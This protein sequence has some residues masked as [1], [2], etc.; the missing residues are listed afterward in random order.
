MRIK[1]LLFCLLLLPYAV[2]GEDGRVKNS[3]PQTRDVRFELYTHFSA[4][5]ILGE[6]YDNPNMILGGNLACIFYLRKSFALGFTLGAF[7]NEDFS[8]HFGLLSLGEG[9]AYFTVQFNLP[10]KKNPRWSFPF[11]ISAGPAVVLSDGGAG[12]CGNTVFETGMKFQIV[13]YFGI[14]L[15]MYNR[16]MFGDLGVNRRFKYNT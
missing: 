6:S 9:T 7:V 12:V 16:A 5:T 4:G 3:G 15:L 11:I 10:L 2:F 14:S 8:L 13:K 1:N